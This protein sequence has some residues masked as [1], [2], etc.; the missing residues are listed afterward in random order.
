MRLP[1][2]DLAPPQRAADRSGQTAIIP[3]CDRE[4]SR[5]PIAKDC[6]FRP[7]RAA[8]S[9]EAHKMRAETDGVQTIETAKEILA[10][11]AQD[12]EFLLRLA[13]G[14]QGSGAIPLGAK[15]LEG[16]GVKLADIPPA[17]RLG[18]VGLPL[19]AVSAGKGEECP[20]PPRT[21]PSRTRIEHK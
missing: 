10:R 15:R 7:N 12:G 3:C 1:K 16:L 20:Q 2:F 11:V 5:G 13:R 17:H 8:A 21:L 4:H 6:R 9:R 14:S 18:A 19:R